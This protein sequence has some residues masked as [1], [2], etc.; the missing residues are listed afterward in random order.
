MKMSLA[1]LADVVNSMYP[2]GSIMT[3]GSIL[4]VKELE[5]HFRCG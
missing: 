1:A 4:N 5:A 3:G 2:Q